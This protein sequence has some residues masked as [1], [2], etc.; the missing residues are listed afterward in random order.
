MKFTIV[1][2]C[3]N[4]EASIRDTIE[5][6]LNQTYVPYEYIIC[7][8]GSKDS[9]V[10]IANSYKD[11]FAKKGIIYMVN[12]EKDGGIYFGMNNGIKYAQGEYIN[13]LNAGDKFHDKYVLS[14]LVK[15]I[16]DSSIDILYGD[17]IFLERG[18]EKL[19][20]GNIERI[21]EGMSISHQGMFIRT[22]LMK[23]RLYDTQYKIAADYDFTLAM[24]LEG[25]IF[26]KT[27]IIIADY[28]GGG[29]SVI[30]FKDNAMECYK[31]Q[32]KAGLQ[33]NMKDILK[34]RKKDFIYIKIKSF[35]PQCIWNFY[36]M[37]R[38]RKRYQK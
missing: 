17:V 15:N 21:N 38:G 18:Y 23:N 5:S 10:D 19:I 35:L 6:V 33:C 4:E 13:F 7:D 3:F 24:Y 27:E 20:V 14:E 28:R 1:T 32:T 2:V 37:L 25:K 16:D 22:S 26:K 31:I 11:V 30:N 12:S 29:A 34:A 9:S 36:N 8:G